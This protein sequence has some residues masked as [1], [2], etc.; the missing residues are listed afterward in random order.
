MPVQFNKIFFMKYLSHLKENEWM[1]IE[2]IWHF[3]VSKGWKSCKILCSEKL[4]ETADGYFIV[5]TIT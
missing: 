2:I 1:K 3:C 4:L 5:I